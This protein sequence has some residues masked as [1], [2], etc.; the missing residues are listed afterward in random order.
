MR[1]M[2]AAS[3]GLC[4]GCVISRTR[5]RCRRSTMLSYHGRV[6]HACFMK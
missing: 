5:R 1:K 2:M 6:S 3:D 4:G